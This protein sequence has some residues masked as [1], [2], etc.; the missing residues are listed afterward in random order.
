[1]ALRTVGND[2]RWICQRDSWR[3]VATFSNLWKVLHG[4]STLHFLS[5][6]W[7]SFLRSSGTK[8]FSARFVTRASIF[9]SLPS[10]NMSS[11]FCLQEENYLKQFQL[12]W[13]LYNKHLFEEFVYMDKKIHQSL[14][15]MIDFLQP[16]SD[17]TDFNGYSPADFTQLLNRF[18]AFDEEMSE[19]A[20][21]YKATQQ[22]R[23]A[24][25]LTRPNGSPR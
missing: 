25:Q 3:S 12:T 10:G 19:V 2:R 5:A 7:I 23:Q 17:Q 9:S 21:L 22:K 16:T 4:Y 13:L 11:L 15:K 6:R 8:R 14:S 24:W 1:M 20:C 18:L